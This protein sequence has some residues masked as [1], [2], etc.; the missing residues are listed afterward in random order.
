MADKI[1]DDSIGGV[2]HN[3]L[4]NHRNPP[5]SK[6]TNHARTPSELSTTSSHSSE[7][8]AFPAAAA[9]QPESHANSPQHKAAAEAASVR[10]AGVAQHVTTFVQQATRPAS[11]RPRRRARARKEKR[12][13]ADIPQSTNPKVIERA[14]RHFERL[15]RNNVLRDFKSSINSASS[16]RRPLAPRPDDSNRFKLTETKK[17]SLPEETSTEPA[18]RLKTGSSARPEKRGDSM[19]A[20]RPG[21]SSAPM[22]VR[23][24][25]DGPTESTQKRK[26]KGAELREKIVSQPV[27]SSGARSEIAGTTSRSRT[28]TNKTPRVKEGSSIRPTKNRYSGST[29]PSAPQRVVSSSLRTNFPRRALRS[30]RGVHH[31]WKETSSYNLRLL[32]RPPTMILTASTD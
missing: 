11:T 4:D 31:A 26:Q 15:Q 27:K 30:K 25:D 3:P 1:A 6:P 13:D 29:T 9:Y 7:P 10:E 2:V 28:S 22:S 18:K 21:K 5:D 20:S 12:S 14:Q 24:G 23:Q 19:S 8:L 32:F 16:T 17:R